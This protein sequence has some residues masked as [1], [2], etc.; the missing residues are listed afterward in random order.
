MYI[1]VKV[2]VQCQSY[3]T[4]CL[5]CVSDVRGT[6]FISQLHN[7]NFKEEESLLCSTKRWKL[8]MYDRW[9]RRPESQ[10]LSNIEGKQQENQRL[11]KR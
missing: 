3:L 9:K 6:C 10:V 7:D 4:Y 1:N 11:F 8:V 2:S 5:T